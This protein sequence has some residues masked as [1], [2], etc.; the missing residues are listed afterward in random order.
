VA[1]VGTPTPENHP[2]KTGVGVPTPATS[3]LVVC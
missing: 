1:G 2:D 3:S